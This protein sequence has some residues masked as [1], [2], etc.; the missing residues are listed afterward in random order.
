MM[1]QSVFGRMVAGAACL[2]PLL[3]AGHAAAQ[4][5]PP[6]YHIVLRSRS[7]E[8]APQRNKQAQ[9]SGGFIDVVQ[10]QPDVVQILMRGTVVAGA[11][12][13]KGGAASMHFVLG[14]DF[15]IVPTRPDLRR[16]RLILTGQVIGA[17]TSSQ[18]QG[19][20][21]EQAAAC[22]AVKGAGQPLLEFCIKPHAVAATQNLFVN[23]R[24]GCELIVVPGGYCLNSTFDLSASAPPIESWCPQVVPAAA[25]VFSADPRLSPRWNY[26]LLPFAA[27]P[28]A[29]F[30]F[31]IV[32][33]VVEDTPT[34]APGLEPLLPPR[35][36]GEPTMLPATQD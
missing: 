29:E 24:T 14:Q 3:S 28:A 22:A 12:T 9:T 1:R 30:G 5:T 19:G 25:A 34:H 27:V 13:H 18:P 23:D 7:G 8:V 17:L 21:A 32:L 15:D 16:P 33:R 35:E 10:R 2:I 26:V 31:R 4:A 36:P 11:E 20:V 6:P